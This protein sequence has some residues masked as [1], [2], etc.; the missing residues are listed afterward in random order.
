MI[1]N[2][3]QHKATLDQ[4]QAGVVDLPENLRNR[5]IG[6]ITFNF[7]P[8]KQDLRDRAI[9]V[10]NILDDFKHLANITENRIYVMIGGA[11]YFMST[12]EEFLKRSG[13]YVPCYAF[14]Q[15]ISVEKVLPDGTV[16][17]TQTFKHE[18]FIEF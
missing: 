4:K 18:G 15:R 2:A 10:I 7:L 13:N 11:P 3:T 12:L 14:S 9:E 8:E 17:K 5:L 6:A 16:T 1:I